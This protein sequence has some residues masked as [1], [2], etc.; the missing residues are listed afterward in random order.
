VASADALFLIRDEADEV[1]CLETPSVL[2]AVG[3]HYRE[4]SQVTDEEVTAI[5]KQPATTAAR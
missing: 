4:F 1:V 3:A 2:W 5:L